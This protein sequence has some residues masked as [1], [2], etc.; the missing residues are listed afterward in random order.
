ML[1]INLVLP[2]LTAKEANAGRST[3]FNSSI[4]AAS[5]MLT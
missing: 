2:I 4:D 5:A 3:K 1:S